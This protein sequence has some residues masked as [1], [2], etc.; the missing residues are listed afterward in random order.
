[1]LNFFLSLVTPH[2]KKLLFFEIL[3]LLK[4]KYGTPLTE[5]RIFRG[6]FICH[7]FTGKPLYIKNFRYVSYFNKIII[8]IK[9]EYETYGF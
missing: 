2:R 4:L 5:F 3:N 8:I 1:M 7:D 6:L 9:I